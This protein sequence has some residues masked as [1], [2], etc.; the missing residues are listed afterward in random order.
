W[1]RRCGPTKTWPASCRTAP[2]P[3]TSACTSCWRGRRRRPRARRVGSRR[4]HAAPRPPARVSP[5][6]WWSCCAATPSTATRGCCCSASVKVLGPLGPALRQ[7]AVSFL[8]PRLA[9]TDVAESYLERHQVQEPADASATA[10]LRQNVLAAYQKAAP[11]LTTPGS[12]AET[13]LLSVP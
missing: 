3:S 5:L 9:D 6:S 4:S 1:R 10:V 11:P 12:P 8:A 7:G 13:F 2:L